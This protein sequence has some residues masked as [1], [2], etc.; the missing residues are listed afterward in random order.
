MS[1]QLLDVTVVIPCYNRW[2]HIQKAI[3]SVLR[4]TY[5]YTHCLVVDDASTDNSFDALTQAYGD[6][7]RVTLL[8][9]PQNK[10]QSAARNHGAEQVKTQLICFLDSDDQLHENAVYG[11]VYLYLDNPKFRGISFGQKEIAGHEGLSPDIEWKAGDHLGL[12]D[13]LRNRDLLHTNTFM[14]YTSDFRASGGFDESLRNKEDIELFL[15]LLTTH[16][17]RYSGS[18][19]CK[20]EE[21]DNQRARHDLKRIIEQG[22]RF[23]TAVTGNKELA[24]K[25]YPQLL[26]SLLEHDLRI[27]LNALYKAKR[28]KEYRQLLTESYRKGLIKMNTRLAKRYLLSF[29]R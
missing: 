9:L 1:H 15:R 21:V 3:S 27:T 7:P 10:G 24:R 16:Q 2:P 20:I 22:S 4:Q 11:R 12:N 6:N 18:P 28:A 14:M 5:K 19:C 25:A 29:I 26:G 13:Y 8:R 23:A 17:A